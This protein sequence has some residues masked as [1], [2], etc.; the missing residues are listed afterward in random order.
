MITPIRGLMLSATTALLLAL[1]AGTGNA[2][3]MA[4]ASQSAAVSHLAA[5]HE[6]GTENV[7]YR[8]YRRYHYHH[9]PRRRSGL[10]FYYN[11]YPRYHYRP[12]YHSYGHYNISAH[13][14]WCYSR[15]RSYRAYDGTFQPYHGPRRRCNSPYDRY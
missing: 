2:A 3:P 13:H 14:R 9:Y 1:P 12:R 11:S 4:G 6:A 15:Y 8:R 10:Y 5:E 7:H